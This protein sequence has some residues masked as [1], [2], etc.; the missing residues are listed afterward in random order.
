MFVPL[1]LMWLIN[2]W[3]FVIGIG[4]ANRSQSPSDVPLGDLA[5][6]IS[7]TALSPYAFILLGVC[8]VLGLA[9]GF[10]EPETASRDAAKKKATQVTPEQ[11]GPGA[12]TSATEKDAC[13]FLRS[14]GDPPRP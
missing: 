8:L 10:A 3:P 7:A 11:T 6:S 4:I 9:A 13:D 14:I 5:G 1:W 2:V 12:E